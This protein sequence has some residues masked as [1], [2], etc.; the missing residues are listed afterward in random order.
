MKLTSKLL[1]KLIIE[2]IKEN[3]MVLTEALGRDYDSLMDNMEG[4]NPETESVGI[5]SAQYPM[6]QSGL[7]QEEEDARAEKLNR[8]LS[9]RGMDNL[10]IDGK[11][12]NDEKSNVIHNPSM[13][14]MEELCRQFEQESYVYGKKMEDGSMEYELRKLN[15][16][17]DGSGRYPGT[18]A[19]T[20][21]LK[22]EE[23]KDE[24]DNYSA[25]NGMR[26]GFPFFG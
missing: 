8:V 26:F 13:E 16:E 20:T 3:K 14:Q 6:A 5:M 9:E 1:K 7:P 21:V 10:P 2:T 24:D 19:T 4:R 15:Y 25:I 22:H 12:G 11:Y 18:V 23:L 17:S